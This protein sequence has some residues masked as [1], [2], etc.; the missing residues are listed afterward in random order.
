MKI[1]SI[2]PWFGGKRN[3]APLIIEELGKHQAYWEPF[4]GSM[5]VLLVKPPASH[6]TV[7]DLHGDLTNLAWV[8]QS[9]RGVELYDRLQRTI[10]AEAIVLEAKRICGEPFD[11]ESPD[12]DRAYWYFVISWAGR[13]GVSGTARTNYQV[14]VRWTPGGGSGGGRFSSAVDSIPAWHRRLRHVL[15]L[16][17]ETFSDVLPKISDANG[18]AIYVDPPYFQRGARSGSSKYLHEFQNGDHAKLADALTRFTKARVVVSYYDDPQLDELY[19][20]W[21]KRKV[22]CQKNLHV[23][24]RRGSQKCTAPEVLLI[25]GPSYAT[26]ETNLFRTPIISIFFRI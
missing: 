6:E 22:Y 17:R 3:L 16:Q 5:S 2:A 15:I 1:K 11:G 25:N 24:N 4:C 8:L 21:T 13:N 19:P 7:N 9:P 12:V 26:P 10:M 14:A 23:Q 18:V 20:G